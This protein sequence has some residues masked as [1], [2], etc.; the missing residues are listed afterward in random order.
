M[1]KFLTLSMLLAS[2]AFTATFASAQSFAPQRDRYDRDR[3]D[4]RWDNRRDNDRNWRSNRRVRTVTQ[5]RIVRQ[6]FRTF[7]ETLRITYLP[8]GR[9]TTQVISR[10]RI[11]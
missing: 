5:T 4:N 3:R 2:F 9:T 10:T 6:G 8:N 1:K 7:R 11:R